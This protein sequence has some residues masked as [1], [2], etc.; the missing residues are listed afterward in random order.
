MATRT[1]TMVYTATPFVIQCDVFNALADGDSCTIAHQVAMG[2]PDR[3]DPMMMVC[4]PAQATAST[5]GYH[6]VHDF[7][8]QDTAH[9]LSYVIV[10]TDGG[11]GVS[12]ATDM[13][14]VYTLWLDQ[15]RQ[16]WQSVSQDN[17]T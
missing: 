12:S 11:V 6:G 10:Q 2:V 15:A 4:Q 7:G 13:L 9:N 14:F 3:T 16:D 1:R 17:N 5:V 8:S